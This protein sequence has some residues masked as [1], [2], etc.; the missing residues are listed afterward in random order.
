MAKHTRRT[1][2]DAKNAL[3]PVL[4]AMG[5]RA[6]DREARE[7]KHPSVKDSALYFTDNGRV[8]C[9]AHLGAS[10]R[11]SYRDISGQRIRRVTERD[12]EYGRTLDYAIRC[13]TCDAPTRSRTG[14]RNGQ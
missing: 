8:L 1:W 12:R 14:R 3:M 2:E 9:G 4:V 11:M 5:A 13:E 6:C 10:A 7:R